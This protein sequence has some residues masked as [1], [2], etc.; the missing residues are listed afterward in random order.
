VV[1]QVPYEV[2]N[3]EAMMLIKLLVT[4]EMLPVVQDGNDTF[5][6]WGTIQD[7]YD[8]SNK[9]RAFFLKNCYFQLS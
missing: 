4:N 9:G 2:R 5:V 7:I 3:R 1:S 8:T 6:T